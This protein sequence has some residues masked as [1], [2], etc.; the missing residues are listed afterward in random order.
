MPRYVSAALRDEKGLLAKTI[1]PYSE[2]LASME[3]TAAQWYGLA[4]LYVHVDRLEDARLAVRKAFELKP[5]DPIV[6][7]LMHHVNVLK[8]A[9]ETGRSIDYFYPPRTPVSIDLQELLND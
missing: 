2:R 9:R 4:R 6:F 8:A 7:N 3:G 1:I 5:T